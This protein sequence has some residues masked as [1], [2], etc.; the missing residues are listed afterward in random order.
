M[1]AEGRTVNMPRRGGPPMRGMPKKKVKKGTVKRLIK[2]ITR[3]NKL[4]LSVVVCC[5]VITAVASVSSSMFL[6]T[7]IN[8]YI[9]PLTQSPSPNFSSG[10][11]NEA[12]V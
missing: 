11:S 3:N 4:R 5:I 7:L 9:L 1:A 12:C 2:L 6:K 8:D 10:E